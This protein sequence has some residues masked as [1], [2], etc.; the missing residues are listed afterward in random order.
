MLSFQGYETS[1]LT[2]SS[3]LLMCAIHKEAQQKII[4]EVDQF[5]NSEDG[6]I[7]NE[8]L[9]SFPYMELVI[10]ESMRLFTAGGIVARETTDEVV[11]SGY[12]I[13]KG[14]ILGICAHAMHRNPNHWGSDADEFRPERFEPENFKNINPHAFIPFSGGRR[15]CIGKFGDFFE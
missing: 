7:T 6:M 15:I 1:A 2:I 5:Y 12:T 8:N 3:I 10:K 4:D 14:T 13:P 11:L 9:N